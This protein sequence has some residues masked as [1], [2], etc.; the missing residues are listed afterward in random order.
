[1]GSS[2][3]SELGTKLADRWLAQL[4]LPGLLLVGLAAIGAVLGQGHALDWRLL[5]THATHAL[6]TASRWTT[7][8]QVLFCALVLLCCAAIGA[9]IRAASEPARLVWSG[10]WPRWFEPLARRL[11]A[12]RKQRWDVLQ[13][14]LVARRAQVP[15]QER[16]AAL[17][18]E[19]ADLSRR[20]DRIALAE[21]TRPTF[22]GDSLVATGTRV[23][24]QY[25][26]DLGTCWPRMWVLL[27][28]DVRDELRAARARLDTAVA[29]SVW[30]GCY[31]VLACF[32]WPAAFIAAGA[33]LAAWMR[34]RTAAAD[35]AEMIESTVDVYLR[36]LAAELGVTVPDGPLDHRTG[37][38]VTRIARKGA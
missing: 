20:R 15:P 11:T 8:G 23:F 34:G 37:V 29:A 25:G 9:L 5:D 6:H 35:L 4:V 22:T 19:L 18:R 31:L 1:M 33:V 30:A 32:W 24:H 38:T 17:L 36:R 3:L 14:Q 16:S 13:A 21:P 10:E 26:V 2:F 28:V 12:R 27:P 7:A